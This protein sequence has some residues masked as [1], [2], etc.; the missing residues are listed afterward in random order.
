MKKLF[1]TLAFVVIGYASVNAQTA[2]AP[3][4]YDKV[5]TAEVAKLDAL[6]KLTEDQKPKLFALELDR[7]ARRGEMKEL[8]DNATDE[9]KASMKQ[10]YRDYPGRLKAI[11]TPEQDKI[12]TEQKEKAKAAAVKQ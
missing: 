7:Q 8:G 6:L 11:L 12:L 3:G 4:K 5:A 2:P 9:Q 1:Y 10:W